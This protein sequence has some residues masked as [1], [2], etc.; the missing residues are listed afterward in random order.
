MARFYYDFSDTEPGQ[1]PAGT[2]EAQSAAGG[3]WTAVV[4]PGATGG[5]V[6]R[7]APAGGAGAVTASL[8]WTALGQHADS[9]VACR[10]RFTVINWAQ[11]PVRLSNSSSAPWRGYMLEVPVFVATR[12]LRRNDDADVGTTLATGAA[13]GAL[14]V[15]TWYG[16]R[17]RR[18]GNVITGKIWTWN[19]AAA[20]FGESTG[21]QVTGNDNA[22]GG[23]LA[24]NYMGV[25]A[26]GELA[27]QYVE[28]DI[29][30]FGTSGD[31]APLRSIVPPTVPIITDPPGP[32]V[33]RG[34]HTLDWLD[35]TDPD[36]AP[37][38]VVTYTGEHRVDA[39]AWSP[40]FAG[41][42]QSDYEWNL[43]GAA[44]SNVQARIKAIGGDGIESD[45]GVG[46]LLTVAPLAPPDVPQITAP[47]GPG[48][49][50]GLVTL[51]WEASEDADALPGGTVEYEGEYRVGTGAWVHLFP[52]QAGTSYP[53]WD[54]T[55]QVGRTA[56]ARVRARD[57][58]GFVS[59]WGYGP[60]LFVQV[61]GPCGP[62]PGPTSWAPY[63]VP[64]PGAWE[65][66]DG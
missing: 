56:Q 19:P 42:V 58:E 43:T 1:Q 61:F 12:N 44:G 22:S 36:A 32:S 34:T 29:I 10:W 62:P 5:K 65:V 46:P 63:E 6:L 9:E 30:G 39:G 11:Y 57:D 40:L 17:L 23:P 26:R 14:T 20:D 33:I 24:A 35:S 47:P 50:A 60:L 41:R 48:V 38:E 3:A 53:G 18:A 51:E 27:T 49:A 2:V 66:C 21:F 54:L 25:G 45:W 31:I 28:F 13:A 37:G 52:W 8:L 4:V 15:S 7:W 59:E 16:S 64:A 55:S